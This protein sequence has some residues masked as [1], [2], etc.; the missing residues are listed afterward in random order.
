MGQIFRT[1]QFTRITI[2]EDITLIKKY[3]FDNN[4]SKEFE[5]KQVSLS[6]NENISL[7]E[8]VSFTIAFGDALESE[9][10]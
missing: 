9:Q 2:I 7:G 1:L 8:P 5:F 6:M 3:N 4:T 10:E